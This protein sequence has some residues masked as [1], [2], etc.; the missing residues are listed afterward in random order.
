MKSYIYIQY[1]TIKRKISITVFDGLLLMEHHYLFKNGKTF[2][3][4]L[5]GWH[6]ISFYNFGLNY[7]F[8]KMIND[9]SLS[10]KTKSELSI[11][12]MHR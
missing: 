12:Y 3:E 11:L 4:D 8:V 9:Y 2:I 5:L 1:H 10:K 6:S 7:G